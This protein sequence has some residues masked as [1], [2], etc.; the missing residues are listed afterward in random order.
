MHKELSKS[1]LLDKTLQEELI[2]QTW[3]VAQLISVYQDPA[4]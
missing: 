2:S 1:Y 3:F 4:E